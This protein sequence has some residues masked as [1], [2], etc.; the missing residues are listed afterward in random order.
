M[1]TRANQGLCRSDSAYAALNNPG[2]TRTWESTVEAVSVVD[3]FG[4]LRHFSETYFANAG[5][6]TEQIRDYLKP[7][8]KGN[9]PQVA[10][11][12]RLVEVL[13]KRFA[14]LFPAVMKAA[15]VHIP[16]FY[17]DQQSMQASIKARAAFEN[18]P[19]PALYA[20]SMSDDLHKLIRAYRLGRDPEVIR[21]AL[22]ER[23]TVSIRSVDR[24]LTQGTCERLP[25]GGL[26]LQRRT[27][28]GISY[29]VRAWNDPPQT[30]RLHVSIQVERRGNQY[31]SAV[32]TLPPLTRPQIEALRLRFTTD[33]WKSWA[34]VTSQLRRSRSNQF[35]IEF[36]EIVSFPVIGRLDAVP[37][38]PQSKRFD[39]DLSWLGGYVFAIPDR[40]ELISLA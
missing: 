28:D 11:K 39:R 10:K 38:L 31:F 30:R 21:L 35:M 1:N 34:E 33:G 23:I 36:E 26:E 6:H 40:E 37:F 22:N 17:Q 8:F 15:A 29:C 19:I 20:K 18:E 2:T 12:K 14:D 3:V 27:I 13:I 5:D 9:R 25:R 24:L 32:P 4:L 7:I 16:R